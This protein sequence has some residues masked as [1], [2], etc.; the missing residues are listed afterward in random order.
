MAVALIRLCTVC[1]LIDPCQWEGRP[2]LCTDTAVECIFIYRWSPTLTYR[3]GIHPLQIRRTCNHR[4]IRYG[5]TH[6]NALAVHIEEVGIDARYRAG[7]FGH[8][9]YRLTGC[10][11]SSLTGHDIQLDIRI[12]QID[13][14]HI[15]QHLDGRSRTID[16]ILIM[17]QL[18]AR[19][20]HFFP[21]FHYR[22]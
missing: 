20:N 5:G 17:D 12:G 3:K 4:S 22:A 6:R 1:F 16:G 8:T 19:C 11:L 10:Y 21:Q 7:L 14:N 15:C 13:L 2:V 18:R 9:L